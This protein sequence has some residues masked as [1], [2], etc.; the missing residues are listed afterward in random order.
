VAGQFVLVAKAVGVI[1][2]VASWLVLIRPWMTVVGRVFSF[3]FFLYGRSSCLSF[4]FLFFFVAHL[5]PP[6]TSILNE[7]RYV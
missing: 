3:L 4:L 7:V 2:S 6:V 1:S 5:D